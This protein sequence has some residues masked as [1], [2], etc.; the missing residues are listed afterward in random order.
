[1]NYSEPST[2]RTTAASLSAAITIVVC[3]YILRW[4]QMPLWGRL[5]IALIPSIPA[6][7]LILFMVRAISQ[8]DE[9]QRKIQIEGLALAFAGTGFITLIYG[10]LRIAEVGLP[11]VS[12]LLIYVLMIVLYGIG[13]VIAGRRYR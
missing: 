13:T 12:A 7:L 5:I 3:A 2:P 10:M 8:L 4:T 9:L 6:I 1:M 11:P